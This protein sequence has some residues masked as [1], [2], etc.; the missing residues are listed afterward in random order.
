MTKPKINLPHLRSI[1]EKAADWPWRQTWFVVFAKEEDV[2]CETEG[3][4][5]QEKAQF[6]VEARNN[7]ENIINVLEEA[8]EI[9]KKEIMFNIAAKEPTN[10]E[11]REWLSQFEGEE[12]KPLVMEKTR[13]PGRLKPNKTS[14]G[15]TND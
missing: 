2:V 6:I 3:K 5:Y 14:G 13:C 1:G 15:E 8:Q 10:V 11:M 7:W 12:P 9:M 4:D